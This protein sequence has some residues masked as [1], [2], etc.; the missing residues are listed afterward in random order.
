MI[1]IGDCMEKEILKRFGDRCRSL[2]QQSG[3]SQEKFA[4]LIEMERTYYSEIEQGKRNV[5]LVNIEKIANGLDIT[6][7]EL[8]RF[9]EE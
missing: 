5:S 9:N 2:R 4:L 3:L 8:F 1:A 6:L 7:E